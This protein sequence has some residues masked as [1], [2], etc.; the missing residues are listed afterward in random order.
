MRRGSWLV[1]FTQEH[2]K[3]H[4]GHALSKF[5]FRHFYERPISK[6][7]I[8]WRHDVDFS[9]HRALA[10]AKIN[11]QFNVKATFL[12]RLYADTYSLLENQIFE[13]IHEIKSLD[14]EI[15]LHFE[16]RKREQSHI[17]IPNQ[18]AIDKGIFR[19]ILGFYPTC[20]SWH[21]P[22]ASMLLINVDTIEGLFNCYGK[23]FFNLENYVSDSNGY[24][25]YKSLR[26]VLNDTKGNGLQVL[27]HPEW[28]TIKRMP[29]RLKILRSLHGRA[30]SNF[31]NYREQLRG[32][33]RKDG[34]WI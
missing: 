26:K 33:G 17:S 14:Q 3:G 25:R 18:I 22:D 24:W 4:L 6:G 5:S 28:W 7:E 1:D 21:N 32:T 34:G 29:S 8:I 11:N 23:S 20:I 15:G 19:E 30:S 12:F 2:Y 10:I 13:I 31:R 9:P 27:I 16:C